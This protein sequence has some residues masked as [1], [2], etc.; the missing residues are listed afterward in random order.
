MWITM[1]INLWITYQFFMLIQCRRGVLG[2]IHALLSVFWK[3]FHDFLVEKDI[4]LLNLH[5]NRKMWIRYKA[6]DDSVS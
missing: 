6:Y 2:I 3:D 1:W 4:N 5:Q